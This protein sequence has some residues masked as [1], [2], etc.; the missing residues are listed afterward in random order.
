MSG[1]NASLRA[2]Q[3]RLREQMRGLGM[4]YAE[5]AAEMARRYKL[6]PRAAWR[7]AW[8]WTLEEAAGRYNALRARG[9]PEAVTSLTGSRLSEWENWPFSA[10]KPPVTGLCLL[11]E[12]Y[13]CSV[14]DLIDVCDREKLSA[15]ELLTLGKTGTG[16]HSHHEQPGPSTSAQPARPD[17]LTPLSAAGPTRAVRPAS[18]RAAAPA[19]VSAMMDA[20]RQ[21][22]APA[23]IEPLAQILA[24]HQAGITSRQVAPD[25]IILAA[26]IDSAR[27]QY[28]ACCY[29]ALLKHLPG[30]LTRL[31]LACSSLDGEDQLRACALSADAYHVAA[32]L[33]LKLNDPALASL[34]ADRSMRAAIDSEDPLSVGASARIITHTLMSTGHLT[35]AMDTASSYAARVDRDATHSPEALSVYGALLLRGAIAAAHH[36]QRDTALELLTEAE[37]AARQ[38]GADSNL[39][40]TAFGPV[41]A[42]MHR[43]NIAVTLGDAGTAVAIARDIDLSA[44]TVIERKASLLLDVARAFVQWGRYEKAYSALRAAEET[45]PE[46]VT[47]RPLV[48]QLI[49]DLLTSA[50][51]SVRAEA[52]QFAARAGVTR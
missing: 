24:S 32:G 50:P 10:R 48:H 47:G 45:A 36:D 26:A 28:Q 6:R 1:H 30:L 15:A 13:Q 42:S 11:A 20:D 41:N 39:R 12:V 44:I 4:S 9:A 22:R 16:R 37:N 2:Q 19:G 25:V 23:G 14:L 49:R 43:V 35:T 34:A 8:G 18:G 29:S 51:P 3:R 52:G 5:I 7:I 27:R 31:Q 40:W 38:L 21:L 17:D 46:E 33:L